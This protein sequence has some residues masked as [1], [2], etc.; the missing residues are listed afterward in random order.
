VRDL[1]LPLS[2]AFQRLGPADA[3]D[4]VLIAGVIYWLLLWLRGTSAMSLLRGVAILAAL[5]LILG[6]L[7]HV[8]V[9]DWLFT[10]SFTALLVAIP[11]IFQPEIRRALERVGRTGMRSWRGRE[12]RDGIEGVLGSG[13]LCRVRRAFGCA[14]LRA[15]PALNFLR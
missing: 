15:A 11:V 3:L 12:A 6:N 8:A 7:F 5:G 1:L 9:V 10:N 14:S 4:I 13:G 2:D